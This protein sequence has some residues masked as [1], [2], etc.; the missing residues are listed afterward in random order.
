MPYTLSQHMCRTLFPAS[1]VIVAM[2]EQMDDRLSKPSYKE[3]KEAED[4]LRTREET[5]EMTFCEE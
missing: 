1:K 5:S 2:V 4:T 3:M